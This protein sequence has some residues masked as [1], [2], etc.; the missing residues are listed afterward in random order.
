MAGDNVTVGM[1]RKRNRSLT[2][3]VRQ[4][5]RRLFLTAFN[6][7]LKTIP[8]RISFEEPSEFQL[9]SKFSVLKLH[10]IHNIRP[11]G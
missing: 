8:E 2:M 1:T 10:H 6:P 5:L 7:S 9:H 3:S 11:P 4:S